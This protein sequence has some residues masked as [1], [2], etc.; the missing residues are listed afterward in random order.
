MV[1][2]MEKTPQLE[3]KKDRVRLFRASEQFFM[4]L[5]DHVGY[6]QRTGSSI[7][8]SK[9]IRNACLEQIKAE[10][11]HLAKRVDHFQDKAKLKGIN[12]EIKLINDTIN[13]LIRDAGYRNRWDK[14][15]DKKKGPYPI[16]AAIETAYEVTAKL[17]VPRM[18]L[19][20][21]IAGRYGIDFKKLLAHEAKRSRA[22]TSLDNP[23]DIIDWP[24]KFKEAKHA[25]KTHK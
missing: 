11:P 6:L 4:L 10:R 2:F 5:D 21:R 7:D 19:L 16:H 15:N 8:F 25:P 12:A 1:D 3:G 24:S 17:A 23:W 13:G 22:S 9:F 18:E 20:A 14:Y